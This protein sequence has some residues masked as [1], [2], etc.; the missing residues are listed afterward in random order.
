MHP[1]RGR[2]PWHR[3]AAAFPDLT[4]MRVVDLGGSLDTWRRAPLR[5]AHLHLVTPQPPGG[6]VDIPAWAEVSVAG[7]C[8]PPPAAVAAGAGAGGRGCGRVDLVYSDGVLEHLAAPDRRRFAA[9]VEG[10]AD[11]HWIRT[12]RRGAPTPL[13]R[14]EL[15]ALFPS[16]TIVPEREFGLTRALVAVRRG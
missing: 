3:L 15:A 2:R 16:S 1:A 13:A 8:D 4:E 5:P 12:R 11:R 14:D 10:L 7:V 6:D 9:V